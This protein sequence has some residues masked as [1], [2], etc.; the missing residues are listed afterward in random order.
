MGGDLPTPVGAAKAY[1]L[2]MHLLSLTPQL[3]AGFLSEC[4][5]VVGGSMCVLSGGAPEGFSHR[6]CPALPGPA[7]KPPAPRLSERT[8]T[9]SVLGRVI[10]LETFACATQPRPPFHLRPLPPGSPEA[11]L[12]PRG[13]L[14]GFLCVSLRDKDS[15]RT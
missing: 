15:V 12:R 13:Y 14:E 10:I 8:C 11:D 7:R 4:S 1:T 6:P 9:P 3:G 2:K 5:G